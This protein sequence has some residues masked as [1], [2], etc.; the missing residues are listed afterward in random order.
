MTKPTLDQLIASSRGDEPTP[1]QLKQLEQ[2]L[3]PLLPPSGGGG[4]HGG[5]GGGGLALKWIA[6]GVVAVGG[7]VAVQQVVSHRASPPPAPQIAVAPPPIVVDAMP[8]PPDAAPVV[9]VAAPPPPHKPVTHDTL[10][11]EAAL[12][13]RARTAIQHGDA[14]AALAA[15]DV[16]AK[17]FAHGTLGEERERIAIEALVAL[18]RRADAEARAQRFDRTFA[19]SVQS[20]RIHA[21][22]RR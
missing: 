5:A 22:L 8:D 1:A 6:A 20:E 15:C 7:G 4:G 11:A 17:K 3:A 9:E 21:L 12:L 10:A 2:K 19:N 16:H 18:G 14:A 13:D